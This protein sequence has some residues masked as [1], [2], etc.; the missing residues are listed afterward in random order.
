MNEDPL[1]GK[2]LANFRVDRVLGRGGMAQV[3]YG[4]DVQLHRPVAINRQFPV[5]VQSPDA[6][7]LMRGDHHYLPQP[8]VFDPLCGGVNDWPT[9][10]CFAVHKL[11]G[12]FAR[13][14]RHSTCVD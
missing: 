5:K 10:Q 11:P 1:I 3:Y 13:P 14:E 8:L 2:Q 6:R 7:D 12:W 9:Y 4:E